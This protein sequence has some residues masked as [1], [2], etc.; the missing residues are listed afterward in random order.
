L[1]MREISGQDILQAREIVRGAI[2]ENPLQFSRTFSEMAGCSLY[3]KPECLQK[4]G[5][6]KIR[7]AYYM[8]SRLPKDQRDK[9]ICTFSAG[10]WAQGAAYAGSLLGVP[11]TVVMPEKANPKKAAAT[12]G[13]GGEVI[14]FGSD[15]NQ[16]HQKAQD[17]AQK[18]G[19]IFINP[20]EN[21][22]LIVGMGTLG[23]EILEGQPDLDA[24]V[25][26][27]G[28]GGL[29]AGIASAAKSKKPGVKVYGVQ[30]RGA[31]A[32][33]RSLAEGKAVEIERVETIA[34]GLAVKRPNENTVEIIRKIV[35][36]VVLVSDDEIKE[37]IF[38]LL[39]RAKLVVEPAGAASLAAVLFAR[40]PELRGRKVASVLTG[41]NIDFH[42]LME[43]LA[44]HC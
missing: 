13:Y 21:L 6:H 39:E 43:I 42:L 1:D 5:C 41:G 23:L 7:G 9:G 38:L 30:P 12:R 37:A 11:V 32:M 27:V 44:S 20:L 29:I 31:D 18:R 19:A 17:L 14:L 33:V 2:M 26:P 3:L 25:V 34:D 28:G 24:I 8:L 16:L 15:S 35:D 22:D 36:E 40:I 10:N 4:N